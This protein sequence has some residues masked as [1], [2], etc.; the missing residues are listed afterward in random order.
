MIG[1]SKLLP[2][3]ALGQTQSS[4]IATAYFEN[5]LLNLGDLFVAPQ[6]SS[7]MSDKQDRG[8]KDKQTVKEPKVPG[9]DKGGRPEKPDSEKAEKTI[10][11]L[12]S[13]S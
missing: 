9:E 10:Q 11:N 5:E 1:F 4:I 12:E 8:S 2:Q 13:E 3:V 7:T 6:M